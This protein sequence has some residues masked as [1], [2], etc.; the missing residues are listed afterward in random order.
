MRFLL[1][2]AIKPVDAQLLLNGHTGDVA[3]AE[4]SPDGE[5]LVTASENQTARTWDARN[6]KELA[7][8][9]GHTEWVTS[10]AFSP[11]GERVV[12]ASWDGTVRIWDV[13]L[14]TR[15]PEE[16]DKILE[17]KEVP[18][19]LQDGVLVTNNP[20]ETKPKPERY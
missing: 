16:I 2:Q 12:T 11:D 3:S 15:S 19:R 18:Y 10:A 14:E 8:L 4:F 20:N 5:R 7:R 1:A 17:E 9:E 6:G 13:H